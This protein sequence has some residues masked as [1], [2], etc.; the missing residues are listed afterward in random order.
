MDISS[1][2]FMVHAIN[3]KKKV[4]FNGEIKPTRG[5]LRQMIKDLG[6]QTKLVVFEAG[7][8]LKWVAL[9][10]KPIK[11]VHLHVVHPNEIVKGG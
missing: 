11:S 10:L 1:K 4:V 5:G 6:R 7:N 3:S 9:E 2:S 8:Q